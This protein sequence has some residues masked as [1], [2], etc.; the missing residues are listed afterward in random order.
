MSTIAYAAL[1][2]FVFSVPWERIFVLPGISIV[3]KATGAVAVSLALLAALMTGRFRRWHP[4]H[5]LAVLFIIWA[6]IVLLIMDKGARLPAKFWTWP[7]LMLVLWMTW[8]IARSQ[9]RL[10]GLLLAYVVGAY[11]AALD[12]ILIYRQQAGALR[13]FAA[14][15]G[16]DHVLLSYI[17]KGQRF[18]SEGLVRTLAEIRR[19]D[20]RELLAVLCRDRIVRAFAREIRRALT[21]KDDDDASATKELRSSTSAVLSRAIAALPDSGGPVPLARWRRSVRTALRAEGSKGSKAELEGT[22]ALLQQKELVEIK[23][24]SVRKT[25]AHV[26]AAQP[27]ERVDLAIEFA[28]IFAKSLT[29]EVIRPASE[30]YFQNHFLT[31]PAG[32]RKQFQRELDAAIRTV[33]EKF[34]SEDESGDF[35][36]VLVAAT[37]KEGEHR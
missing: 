4:F 33:I 5:V 8:E 6:G 11:V 16:V 22:I 2:V 17:E 20:A 24:A 31:L 30:T 21:G 35:F 18:P 26:H 12:T 13:R 7:Q 14:E 36:Q 37:S 19:E 29:D 15:L 10:R 3:P 27:D 23:G 28:G 34:A 1:W 32:Q 25:A 9:G